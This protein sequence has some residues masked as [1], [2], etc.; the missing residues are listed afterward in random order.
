MRFRAVLEGCCT[1]PG[2]S[3][4][5]AA[6]SPWPLCSLGSP[7]LSLPP[8]CLTPPQSLREKEISTCSWN[9]S[10]LFSI[11]DDATDAPYQDDWVDTVF[12]PQGKPRGPPGGLPEWSPVAKLGLDARGP[13]R[14]KEALKSG[15]YPQ[16]LSH[17]LKKI[18]KEKAAHETDGEPVH[19]DAFQRGSRLTLHVPSGETEAT[20]TTG[21]PVLSEPQKAQ[22]NWIY[23]FFLKNPGVDAEGRA[24]AEQVKDAQKLYLELAVSV[25]VSLLLGMILCCLLFWW[26]RKRKQRLAAADEAQDDA[27]SDSSQ[28]D[29]ES[30]DLEWPD[31]RTPRQ[32]PVREQPVHL[33]QGTTRAAPARLDNTWMTQVPHE[34]QCTELQGSFQLRAEGFINFILLIW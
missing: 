1:W 6:E 5:K 32:P 13:E 2:E 31:R 19:R 14:R 15:K 23:G 4:W 17:V 26:C 22:H 34:N 8:H 10:H 24:N 18:M 12:V 21:A 27:S 28:S 7:G 20:H 16:R 3:I 11:L 9:I 30:A 29:E 33:P 25:P